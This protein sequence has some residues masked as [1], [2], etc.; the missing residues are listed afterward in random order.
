MRTCHF[1]SPLVTKSLL[2]NSRETI[3]DH[4]IVE[5]HH[6]PSTVHVKTYV[7]ERYKLTVYHRRD[8]GELFDLEADPKEINNLWNDPD[9]QALKSDLIT[10]LLFAEMGKESIPMPRVSGA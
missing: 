6:D 2:T 8:Y 9:S 1:V 4:I 10:S 5:N 7:D 3:R